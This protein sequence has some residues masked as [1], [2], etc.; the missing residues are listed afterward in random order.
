MKCMNA[1]GTL[2]IAA[3]FAVVLLL[4]ACTKE[5]LVAPCGSDTANTERT[6]IAGDEGA[7]MSTTDQYIGVRDPNSGSGLYDRSMDAGE[8]DPGGGISDDGD[9]DGDK[10]RKQRK[11][12]N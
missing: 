8:E 9:D 5:E 4:S 6:M 12:R 10:E 2:N 1:S 3:L 7:E 11:I